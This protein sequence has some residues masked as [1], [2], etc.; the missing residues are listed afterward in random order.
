M[1]R[2]LFDFVCLEERVAWRGS[3]ARGSFQF[4]ASQ[5]HRDWITGAVNNFISRFVIDVFG[6]T[7]GPFGLVWLLKDLAISIF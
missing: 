6:G 2:R 3:D 7:F 1:P 5:S 4:Q